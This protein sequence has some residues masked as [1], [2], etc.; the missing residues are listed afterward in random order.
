LRRN[1]TET[2]ESG[3]AR[4]SAISAAVIRSWRNATITATRSGWVRFATRRGAE[5]RSTRPASPA[6]LYLPTHFL[7][8]RTL[9]PNASAAAATVE[10]SS[11]TLSASCRRPYQLRAALR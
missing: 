6:S 8:Q 10:P 11:T 3:I 9:T 7:A 5:E 4:V 2:V 1:T